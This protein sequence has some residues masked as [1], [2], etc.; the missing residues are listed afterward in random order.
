L[1]TQ[2]RLASSGR[3]WSRIN[4]KSGATASRHPTFSRARRPEVGAPT[5]AL[6]E[7][8]TCSA[9]ALVRTPCTPIRCARSNLAM[10]RS[11]SVRTSKRRCCRRCP[12]G[13][14]WSDAAY[15]ACPAA[16]RR[17]PARGNAG[18]RP[19]RGLVDAQHRPAHG[20]GRWS[21]RTPCLPKRTRRRHGAAHLPAHH[22]RGHRIRRRR[23]AIYV[24]VPCAVCSSASHRR[25]LAESPTARRA[26]QFSAPTRRPMPKSRVSPMTVLVRSAL[27]SLA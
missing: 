13:G 17:Q 23:S 6:R 3:T 15:A 24:L 10:T 7:K 19:R 21:N 2:E 11:S 12:T 27:P 25:R 22:W 18:L 8:A 1:V 5:A 26:V 9:W 14:R 20:S 4:I 16:G